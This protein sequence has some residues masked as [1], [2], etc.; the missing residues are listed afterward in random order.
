MANLQ[1]EIM[2][3]VLQGN[4]EYYETLSRL[5]GKQQK[6]KYDLKNLPYFV[7]SQH[8][9]LI[10]Q[11][12]MSSGECLLISLLDFIH[13]V[14]IQNKSLPK[15]RPILMLLDEIELALHPKAVGKL[16]D[17]L[18]EIVTE[19]N[20]M[21]VFLTTH[22]PEVIRRI[23]PSNIYMLENVKG[24]VSS[25]APTYPSYAIRELYTEDVYDY[26][27]FCEDILAK[28]FIERVINK[29]NL[30]TSKRIYVTPV[31]GWDQVLKLHLEFS[32]NYLF[33]RGTIGD[34]YLPSLYT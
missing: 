12:R 7:K 28:S 17:R 30:R 13:R 16:L 26:T 34:L 23:S 19:Y 9:G 8:G 4:E 31:G 32:N 5:Q 27:I 21:T 24:A 25:K 22:A 11:Y 2:F 10:S 29:Q 1:M 6:E 33:G 14:V 18:N 3:E 15:D 20:N